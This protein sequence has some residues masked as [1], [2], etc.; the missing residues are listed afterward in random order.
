[1]RLPEFYQGDDIP[2]TRGPFTDDEGNI[3]DLS[4]LSRVLFRTG[5]DRR[6]V[7]EF[8]PSAT[9]PENRVT[10]E[11]YVLDGATY[12][13]ALATFT[14]Q[15][16]QTVKMKQGIATIEDFVGQTDGTLLDSRRDGSG[17]KYAYIIKKHSL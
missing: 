6:Y 9:A 3:F 4:T 15:S 10:F 14:I 5:T 2:V 1:M 7:V 8:S 16:D 11:D 17:E 13:N 12:P